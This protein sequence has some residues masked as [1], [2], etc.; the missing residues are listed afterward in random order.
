[1]PPLPEGA[2]DKAQLLFE[3]HLKINRT[4]PDSPPSGFA[5]CPPK[6]YALFTVWDLGKPYPKAGVR[7]DFGGCGTRFPER[8]ARN[9]GRR[10]ETDRDPVSDWRS[11]KVRPGFPASFFPRNSCTSSASREIWNRLSGSPDGLWCR[12]GDGAVSGLVV[13]R[14]RN[15]PVLL[16]SVAGQ[17]R[18][19]GVPAVRLGCGVWLVP[20]LGVLR[21]I[22]SSFEECVWCRLMAI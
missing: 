1:M 19:A 14:R 4:T 21:Q 10:E 9:L 16:A 8:G 6:Q 11:W 3:K 12:I 13:W 20:G 17:S 2:E 22:V 15:W 18:S 7:I 5:F